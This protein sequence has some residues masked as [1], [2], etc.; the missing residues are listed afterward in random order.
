MPL[1]DFKANIQESIV[2]DVVGISVSTRP[3]CIGD[4]YL[5]YLS[6]IQNKYNLDI[7]VELGLQTVNY[8][9]LKKINRGSY[10]S[11]VYRCSFKMP[12][13][14]IRTCAHLILNLPWDNMV[15]VI[16]N[17]KV[18]NALRIDEVKLHA[19]YI[20]DG[21]I[22]G[23]MYKMGEVEL[24]SKEEYQER[25]IKFLEY[26]DE[27]IVVQRIIGRAP[28]ENSLFVNWNESW[29]KIRDEIVEEMEKKKY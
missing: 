3:D 20:V 21:T 19:L 17:A 26:L 28:E 18:L 7:T 29:W 13:Y 1:E 15:D 8:H 23:E 5:E 4:E 2:E 14:N 11:R 27:D 9:S 22:L 16:E 6:H 24:I 12:K 25:V 10:F